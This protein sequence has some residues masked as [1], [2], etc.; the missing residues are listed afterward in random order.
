[1]TNDYDP[2]DDLMFD[3][4]IE[5]MTDDQAIKM[6]IE[7][8]YSEDEAK[9]MVG[10]YDPDDDEYCFDDHD[11]DIPDFADDEDHE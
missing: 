1:M 3:N 6:L 4:T 10:I 9:R 5:E 11:R 2:N 7:E 8:G